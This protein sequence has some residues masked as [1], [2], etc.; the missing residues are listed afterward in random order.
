M[1]VICNIY[2]FLKVLFIY[3]PVQSYFFHFLPHFFHFLSSFNFIL[4][5]LVKQCH[6]ESEPLCINVNYNG[7]G[8]YTGTITETFTIKKVDQEIKATIS[9]VNLIEEEKATIEITV[10]EKP[11]PHTHEYEDPVFEWIEDYSCKAVFTSKDKDDEQILDCMVTNT[12]TDL[13]YIKD[14]EIVNSL[15]PKWIYRQERALYGEKES[16]KLGINRP[17]KNGMR[18]FCSSICTIV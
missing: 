3:N 14:G 11:Q 12:A 6:N 8:N 7:Q 15:Y 2:R 9:S 10:T 17:F 18:P 13:T 5:Y 4:Q 1:N 16:F